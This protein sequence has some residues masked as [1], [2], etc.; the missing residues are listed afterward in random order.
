MA[1]RAA[2][3][4]DDAG[5]VGVGI[6]PETT[7]DGNGVTRTTTLEIT[8][9]EPGE[10]PLVGWGFDSQGQISRMPTATTDTFVM[11]AAGDGYSRA[12]RRERT[13]ARWG[14]GAGVAAWVF[15]R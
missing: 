7:L 6:Q 14:G 13:V 15:V 12:R 1:G 4:L 5:N 2:Y 9:G 8:G 11:A 3:L 10:R